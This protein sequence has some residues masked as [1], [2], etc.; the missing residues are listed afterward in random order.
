[1]QDGVDL[2]VGNGR[3]IDREAALKKF[4]LACS[5]GLPRGCTYVGIALKDGDELERARAFDLFEQSCAV[6]EPMACAQLGTEYLV[7]AWVKSEQSGEPETAAYVAANEHLRRACAAEEAPDAVKVWGFSVRGYACGNLAASYENGFAVPQDYTT[8]LQLNQ[9][10][11]DLGWVRSCAQV[12]YFYEQGYGVDKDIAK[13]TTLYEA[14]CAEQDAMACNN[15]AKLVHPEDPARARSLFKIACDQQ[16]PGSC[17]A[18]QKG[19]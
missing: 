17:E 11:C 5:G 18:N 6:E 19:E 4:E 9:L 12:G 15:L 2:W 1:M 10:S 8:A 13:A 16:Y 14:A 7:Q 3:E